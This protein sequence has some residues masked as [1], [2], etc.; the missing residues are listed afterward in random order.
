MD[1]AADSLGGP[2]YQRSWINHEILA[3]ANNDAE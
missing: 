3:N 1:P 2:F